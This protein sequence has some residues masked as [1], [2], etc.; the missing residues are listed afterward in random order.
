LIRQEADFTYEHV[1]RWFADEPDKAPDE[2]DLQAVSEL[3]GIIQPFTGNRWRFT[4]ETF[5]EYLAARYVV[6]SSRDAS[7]YLKP[8]LGM[9]WTSS[10]LRFACSI[11]NDA[12]PLL[13]LV[14]DAPGLG[15][16]TQMS[17]LADMVAQRIHASRDVI[18][19]SCDRI[20]SWLEE[21][22]DGWRVATGEE[23]S[24]VFPEPKWRLAARNRHTKKTGPTEARP[25]KQVLQ[26]VKAMHRA[27]LGPA[28]QPL[29]NRLASST[30]EVV[31][32]VGESLSVEGYFE[33]RSFSRGES[34]LFAAEVCEI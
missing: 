28:M 31:R 14:L 19:K 26:A 33:G 21:H 4:H 27:R 3:T 20:V 17:M 5:R 30:N 22:F 18:G 34:D 1:A 29:T 16:S 13:Q 6:E 32:G 25:D 11:T 24:E 9:P 7:E 8:T 10:V 15:K 12:T 2:A 23:E